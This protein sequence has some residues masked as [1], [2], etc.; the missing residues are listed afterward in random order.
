MLNAK[1]YIYVFI[2]S[3]GL[4]LPFLGMVNLFDWDEVNFAECAREMLSRGDYSQVMID[5][6]PFWEK[7]PLFIWMQTISMKLFGISNFAARLPNV[8]AAFFTFSFIIYIGE[9]LQNR[10][11]GILWA[12]V[13][14]GSFLP[15]IYFHSGIID[16][17]F[18]LFIMSGIYFGY[19]AFKTNSIVPYALSGSLIGLSIITKGPVGF[20]LFGTPA[21]LF[22]I[23]NRKEFN[24][25]SLGLVA[26]FTSLMISGGSWFLLLILQGEEHVIY[27][28][29]HYQ[30]RLFNSEDAG[31]GGPFYYH[32]IV[33][34]IGCFPASFFAMRNLTFKNKHSFHFL[35]MLTLLFTLVLF[36]IV[37]TK[38]IH[39]S[40]LCYFPLTYLAA[41]HLSKELINSKE[42]LKKSA[43]T[44]IISLVLYSIILLCF[45]WV[46]NDPSS[47]L[48]YIN[49]D[50]FTKDT[51]NQVFESSLLFYLPGILV[52]FSFIVLVY[53]YKKKKYD[54]VVYTS[55]LTVA[56]SILSASFMVERVEQYTQGGHV[57]LC[58]EFENQNVIIHPIG[59]KSFVPLYFGKQQD[60]IIKH[61][62]TLLEEY[63][64]ANQDHLS[65]PIYFTSKSYKKEEVLDLY[66][67]IE[68]LKEQGGFALYKRKKEFN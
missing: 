57:S 68:L 41:K 1:T 16:P 66:P 59:F 35:M 26:F 64:L 25:S 29:I 38:I 15:N 8:F 11:F 53:C 28:F 30:I 27:D 39:Y 17:W 12:V 45:A 62:G 13:F 5:Y 50:R 7:P 20:I 44:L 23:F 22:M 6:I 47:I 61:D 21:L 3:M 46:L 58:K 31:H 60:A 54:L 14:C 4:F 19:Q 51:L 9:K 42:G 10:S 52:S 2:I 18:N 43:R 63:F 36:S 65:L 48:K 56:V 33:L 32:I 49:P 40:S 34:F 67:K 55:F 37:Q 24:W